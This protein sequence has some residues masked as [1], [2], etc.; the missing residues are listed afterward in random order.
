MDKV[1]NNLYA[2]KL[3]MDINKVIMEFNQLWNRNIKNTGW[4]GLVTN[5]YLINLSA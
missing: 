3:Y 2:Y 1:I 4:N 5:W